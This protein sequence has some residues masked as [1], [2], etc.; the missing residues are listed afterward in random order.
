MNSFTL[1]A[2]KDK[3]ARMAGRILW[4]KKI[5]ARYQKALEALD[6]TIGLFEPHYHVGSIKPIYP[7]RRLQMFKHGA[8]GR[9]IMDALRNATRPLNPQEIIAAVVQALEQPKSTEDILAGSVRSNLNYLS[10]RGRIVK[11]GNG[12]GARWELL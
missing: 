7:R 11:V 3:R 5:L 10:R 1:P 2:L 9:H 12:Q 4:L 8:L 6:T